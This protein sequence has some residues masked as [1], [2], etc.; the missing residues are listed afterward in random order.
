MGIFPIA[1]F[2]KRG[3]VELKMALAATL[4]VLG[5][6]GMLLGQT[7]CPP[8]TDRSVVGSRVTE[9][10]KGQATAQ[11]PIHLIGPEGL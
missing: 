4:L 9:G 11:G 7:L 1:E 8:T 3:Q 5:R 2:L 10:L 6:R